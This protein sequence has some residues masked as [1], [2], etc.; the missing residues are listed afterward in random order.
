MRWIA[1][2]AERWWREMGKRRGM[3]GGGERWEKKEGRM[4][5][6]DESDR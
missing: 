6:K 3:R 4:E 1:R 5:E 2:E